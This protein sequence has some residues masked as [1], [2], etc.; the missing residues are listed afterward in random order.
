MLLLPPPPAS[1]LSL[2]L[3]DTSD[4]FACLADA[5]LH[6]LFDGAAAH[7]ARLA[8]ALD[9]LRTAGT[10]KLMAA[11]HSEVILAAREAD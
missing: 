8:L 11:R 4:G 7:R 9:P 2:T 3:G 6:E 10:G 5:N 1:P